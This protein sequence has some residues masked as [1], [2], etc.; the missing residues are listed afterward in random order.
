VL[1]VN[2]EFSAQDLDKAMTLMFLSVDPRSAA[3]AEF[4]KR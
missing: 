2:A 1:G 4:I 3:G